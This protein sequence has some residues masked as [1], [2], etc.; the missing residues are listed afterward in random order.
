MG[1]L[2]RNTEPEG[3]LGRK[4]LVVLHSQHWANGVKSCHLR[5]V[6]RHLA[7]KRK[8]ARET[9]Q[10]GAACR[11]R[12]KLQSSSARAYVG[13]SARHLVGLYR[14]TSGKAGACWLV[15]KEERSAA[16]GWK[17][18]KKISLRIC[19]VWALYSLT[20]KFLGTVLYPQLTV[21]TQIIAFRN[22]TTWWL[23]LRSVL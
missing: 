15:S 22:L 5:Q 1:I 13:T 17:E 4:T 8:A 3:H 7:G 14:R 21:G 2:L 16:S 10:P 11:L 6:Q 18:G 23:G 9:T 19:L 20:S 12:S